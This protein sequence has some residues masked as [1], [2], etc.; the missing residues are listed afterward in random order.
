M[1]NKTMAA[2]SGLAA[3]LVFAGCVGTTALGVYDESVPEESQCPLEIRNDLGVILYDNLPVTWAPDSLLA[4]KTT[5]TLPPGEHTFVVRYYETVQYG[6]VQESVARTVT[7][8]QEFI[9]GHSYRIYQQKIWL[10]LITI[11][12]IKIK[13]VT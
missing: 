11:K 4:S 8:A 6:S 13:D 10:I 12:N 2:L 7:L 5:I 1:K 9:P 3:L